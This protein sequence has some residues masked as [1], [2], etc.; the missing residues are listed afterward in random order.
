MK[1][2]TSTSDATKTTTAV[3]TVLVRVRLTPRSADVRPA[4][5]VGVSDEDA[6]EDAGSAP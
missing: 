1:T 2:S 3:H 5:S 4:T 6:G